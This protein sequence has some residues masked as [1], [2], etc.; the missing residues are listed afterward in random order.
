MRRGFTAIELAVVLVIILIVSIM[1]VPALEG[2][3]HEAIK[4]KCLARVRQ[5][6]LACQMYQGNHQGY[7]PSCRR[8][9]RPDD[10]TAP[11][12]TASLAALYPDYAPK[13]YLFQCRLLDCR[14]QKI[15]ITPIEKQA[16]LTVPQRTGPYLNASWEAE[17]EAR[18]VTEEDLEFIQGFRAR[19]KDSYIRIPE[20]LNF[21]DGRR[22]LLEIRDLVAA[23]YFGFQAQRFC[24]GPERFQQRNTSPDACEDNIEML[25]S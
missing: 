18:G 19:L 25:C 22:T 8:S 17:L 10:P 20:I 6:G 1:L 14:P 21:I 3:R 5:I 13:A 11:D 2:G 12:P 23:E 7:W 9:V 15:R 24:G 16:S 4:T